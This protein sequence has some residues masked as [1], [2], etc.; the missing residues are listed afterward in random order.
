MCKV[1]NN[2]TSNKIQEIFI[3]YKHTYI[4][5]PNFRICFSK[6]NKL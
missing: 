5:N 3:K 2:N 4:K 1:N 6:M